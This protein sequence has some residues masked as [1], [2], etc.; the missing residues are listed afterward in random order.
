MVRLKH[1]LYLNF[2]Q[3]LELNASDQLIQKYIAELCKKLQ[4]KIEFNLGQRFGP[5]DCEKN[6]ES[7]V[8]LLKANNLYDKATTSDPNE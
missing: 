1:H 7:I 8:Q 5:L 6:I 2:S 3:Q 4:K